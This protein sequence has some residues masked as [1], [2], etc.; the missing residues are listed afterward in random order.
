ML[1]RIWMPLM[2][3]VI[4][5]CSSDNDSTEI[6]KQAFTKSDDFTI[7]DFAYTHCVL[8]K[9]IMDVWT[10]E[11]ESGREIKEEVIYQ[12][13]S[14]KTESEIKSILEN[15]GVSKENTLKIVELHIQQIDNFKN[16]IDKN[17]EFSTLETKAQEQAISN[18]V[19]EMI[20]L[21]PGN[22]FHPGDIYEPNV[23]PCNRDKRLGLRDCFEDASVTMGIGLIG[24]I[25]T[26]GISILSGTLVAGV[27]AALCERRVLRAWHNCLDDAGIVIH[28]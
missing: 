16:F 12:I 3:L 19:S 6:K 26:C 5:G 24:G 25:W 13:Q 22:I 8:T 11:V 9:D 27:Q 23:H 1:K 7:K 28:I 14:A 17:K 4:F 21:N 15:N 10:N 2:A 20:T 18:A